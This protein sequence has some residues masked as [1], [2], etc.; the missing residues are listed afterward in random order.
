M[1]A[2]LLFICLAIPLSIG[3]TYPSQTVIGFYN[4]ENL[5]DTIKEP[6]KQDGDYTPRG[7]NKW[8]SG[9][10]LK[11]INNISYVISHIS[12]DII[13]LAEVENHSVLEDLISTPL[14]KD[15]D[16]VHFPSHDRRGIGT[17]LL[18]NVRNVDI[19][20][21]APLAYKGK[22]KN[23]RHILHV[24]CRIEETVL[25]LLVCHFPSVGSNI[26]Q[27]EAAVNSAKYYAD[28]IYVSDNTSNIIIMGD[29]N[30][31]PSDKILGTF[32]SAKFSPELRYYNPY[33]KLYRFGFG[34]YNYRDKWNLYDQILL[35]HNIL[36]KLK[37]SKAHIFI[38]DFLVVPTGKYKN[39]PLR[40][41]NVIDGR[42]GYSDHFPVYI[43]LDL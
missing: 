24:K 5:F 15:Y 42:Y 16:Y 1:F 13:G 41:E 2:R 14:L 17:A 38:R 26:N 12:G 9:K 37:N 35:N 6:G 27:R 39:H 21:A 10:Y 19:L 11:K 25:D 22:N 23:Q 28:S 40:F 18:Y 20:E 7:K 8:N 36:P 33:K 3:A 31:N 29:L 30:A 4:V 43:I 32:Y 34:T